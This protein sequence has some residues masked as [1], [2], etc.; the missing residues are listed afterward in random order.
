MS[1]AV[2]AKLGKGALIP[3][4]AVGLVGL[5]MATILKGK[6]GFYGGLLAQALVVI[7]FAVHLLVSK[8][9]AKMEPIAVMAMAM[10]SYFVKI[11]ILGA[12]FFLVLNNI[13]EKSLNRASFGVISICVT[14]AWLAG[15][16]RAFFKL[17]MQMPLPPKSETNDTNDPNDTNEQ[18]Q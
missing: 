6:S 2:E 11:I 3:A 16:V 4:S 10:L 7:F 13:S 18:V 17:R 14:I 5:I 8:Y 15:E 1:N 9:S 12:L